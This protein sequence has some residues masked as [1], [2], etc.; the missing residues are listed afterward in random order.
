M[1][2]LIFTTLVILLIAYS[3]QGQAP[4]AFKYQAIART[5]AGAIIANQNISL[6]IS[7]L[8]GGPTGSSVYC[9]THNVTSNGFGMM[10]LEIGNGIYVSG[11]FT[12]IDWGNSTYYV[13]IEMDETGGTGYHPMGTSQLL[14]VPYALYA[15][16]TP[17]GGLWTQNGNNIYPT[18]T[19]NVGIGITTPVQKFDVLGN[20]NISSDSNYRINNIK[21]LSIKGTGNIFLGASAG[22]ANSTGNGLTACGSLALLSN[23]TGVFNTAIGYTCLSTNT[24]GNNNCAYGAYA[25]ASNT[26]GSDNTACG[27]ALYSNTIGSSNTGSGVRALHLNTEGNSNCAN[28][29]NALYFNTTG[30]NNTAVG[31]WALYYNT[32]GNSNTALGYCAF[33]PGNYTNSMALGAMAVAISGDNQVHIGDASITSIQGQVGWTTYSDARIK[34]NVQKDVPGLAFIKLL[35]PVTYNY[36]VDAENAITGGKASDNW[37]GKYDIEKIRFTGFIAQDV[38]KAAKS[39]GYDFSGVDKSGTMMGLRYADFTVPLVKAVQEQQK[40]IEQLQKENALMKSQLNKVNELQAQFDQLKQQVNLQKS[41]AN[42]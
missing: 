33:G 16:T 7:L 31:M 8:E 19:G 10:N 11:N 9:E 1:K 6:R 30:S 5:L 36:S 27:F 22:I 34:N 38:D 23:T 40:M 35:T 17:G 41:Q 12:S 28:G 24:T 25:L 3:V 14:S 13:K 20:I 21:V 37:D 4:Q 2:R 18:N 15:G 32:T 26:T 39:I 42:N 29:M